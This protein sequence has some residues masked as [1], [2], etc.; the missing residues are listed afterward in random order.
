MSKQAT[1]LLGNRQNCSIIP[2]ELF[3]CP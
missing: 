2:T 1:G 3:H